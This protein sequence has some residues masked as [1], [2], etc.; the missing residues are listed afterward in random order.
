VPRQQLIQV[1]LLDKLPLGTP[2]LEVPAGGMTVPHIRWAV[3]RWSCLCHA[4]AV[5]TCVTRPCWPAAVLPRR[6]LRTGEPIHVDLFHLGLFLLLTMVR[7][8][9]FF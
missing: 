7:E 6:I 2:N 4:A 5:S 3:E 1:D 8:S 9:C